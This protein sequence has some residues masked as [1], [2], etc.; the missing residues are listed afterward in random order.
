MMWCVV[1]VG[2]RAPSPAVLLQLMPVHLP[3]RL[4]A[5]WHDPTRRQQPARARCG[6]VSGGTVQ[7]SGSN[8]AGGG[9]TRRNGQ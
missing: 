1:C 5:R 9:T 3:R 6:T 7:Y 2:D 8:L 4:F